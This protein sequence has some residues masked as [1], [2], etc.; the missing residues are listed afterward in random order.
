[1]PL[2]AVNSISPVD[3]CSLEQPELDGVRIV[4]FSAEWMREWAALESRLESSYLTCSNAWTQ[5]WIQHYGDLVPH[6]LA[7]ATHANE[8]VGMCLITNGVKQYDGPF[9]IKTLH[10]GTAGEPE[11]ESVCVEYNR[12]L[13]APEFL[14]S[15]VRQLTKLIAEHESCECLVVDGMAAE[16]AREFLNGDPPTQTK[17][18]PSYYCDLN[19]FRSATAEPWR[20]FGE[21][22]RTNLRRALRDLG[23][24]ELDWANDSEL[25]LSL[26][27]EMIGYH[28]ARWNAAGKPGVFSSPRF[29]SFHRDLIKTL[30]PQNR[31]VLI[32]ARQGDRVLGILYL[33]IEQNRL[34]YYQAGLPD[35][36]SKHSLGNV[37]QYLTMLEGARRGYDAF[38]FMAGDAQYKRVLST[39]QNSVFWIRWRRPSLKFRF[40]DGIRSLRGT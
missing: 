26:Y 21:S 11:D 36:Q 30:V 28:Q 9:E 27:D 29:T 39:N 34:L 31:A 24:L 12:L 23:D 37:T 40:L 33:L 20:L 38:D 35:H 13:V 3:G 10:I 18:V 2:P 6:R 8:I 19:L 22:T 5:T 17:E 4:G 15:F 14:P 1:M 25:A 32:R 7:V 16:E